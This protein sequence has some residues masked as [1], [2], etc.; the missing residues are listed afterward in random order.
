ME[1]EKSSKY[2]PKYG[3]ALPW[4][5]TIQEMYWRCKKWAIKL[6]KIKFSL[7]CRTGEIQSDVNVIISK[8][9]KMSY[10]N[11]NKYLISL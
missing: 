6:T 3:T 1:Y 5:G 4:V 9:E 8:T 11:I 10:K 2:Q 7:S